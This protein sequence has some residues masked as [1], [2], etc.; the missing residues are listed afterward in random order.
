MFHGTFEGGQAPE[1]T[2]GANRA[3]LKLMRVLALDTSSSAASVAVYDATAHE[4]LFVESREMA[5]GHAEALAPMVER[6]IASLD[7]GVGSIGRI[8]VCVG[9]GSF[10]G[11]R[12]A[13]AMARAMGFA[14]GVP[15]VGVSTL[16]AFVTP[17]LRDPKPGLIVSAVD[18]KHGRV[19][20]QV[21]EANGR[22]LFAPRVA[23][24]REA[25]RWIGGGPLRF[26][27]NGGPM[28]AEE[29]A[30]GGAEVDASAAADYPDI[31]AVAQ[32][33]AALDPAEAPARPIYVK[34]PDAQPAEGYAIARAGG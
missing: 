24:V 26:A 12:I 22:P 19:Y 15:V 29:A 5:L 11:I 30:R 18:A 10:T 14:L 2:L 23:K 6:A 3:R 16:L 8:A 28:L 31:V 32:M 4:T 25:A 7:G 13:L 33:G 27:G 17:L 9:P 1:E 20:L 34:P 21:F